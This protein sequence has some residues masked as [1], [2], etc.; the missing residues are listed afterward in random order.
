MC[1]YS[2]IVSQ[3]ATF[4]PPFLHPLL[5]QLPFYMRWH[6][7]RVQLTLTLHQMV[8]LFSLVP[9]KLSH[10]FQSCALCLTPFV[11]VLYACLVPAYINELL[12]LDPAFS[13]FCLSLPLTTTVC[14]S[15]YSL[16]EI[17]FWITLVRWRLYLPFAD[18][19]WNGIWILFDVFMCLFCLQCHMSFVS[20]PVLS[21]LMSY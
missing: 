15:V 10:R 4:L 20:I 12:V 16:L 6:Y 3:V 13:H 7:I 17:T 9:C 18:G 19:N 5:G 2:F 11:P 21:S 14:Q 1:L 8:S